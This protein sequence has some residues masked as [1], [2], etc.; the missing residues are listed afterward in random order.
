MAILKG[1]IRKLNGSAGDF[2]FKQ[3]NGQTVVSE[4][5]TTVKNARTASQ[6][7]HRTKWANMVQMYKGI[8]PLLLCGFENKAQSVSDYNMFMKVNI[9]VSPVYLSK[10]DVAGGACIA[11]PYQLTQGTLP[12]IVVTGSG[13]TRTTNISVGSLSI[14]ADTT[15]K[16]FSDAVVQNNADYDYGD[17][18]SFFL[19][20][21]KTNAVTGVPYCQFTA[22]AVN[23]DKE[24]TAKLQDTVL[25]AGFK[26]SGGVLA[27]DVTDYGDCVYAWVHSRKSSS[28]TCVSTQFL[29][30]NNSL[31]PAYTS[32]E[33]CDSASTSYGDSKDVFL[34]PDGTS[35][36]SGSATTDSSSGDSSSGSG[37]SSG[38]GSDSGSGSS[39]GGSS[40]GG[41]SS[42]DDGGVG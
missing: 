35:T 28:K 41:S 36:T 38:S 33:A 29:L 23:L 15:V 16:Q 1:L 20:V 11:A 34:S 22:S 17:Q 42:E 24:S 12:S 6:M 37:G 9:N 19:I 7:K 18:I 13:A 31:L 30:D 25:T 40:S 39:S 32:D 27:A 14:G 26:V 4:K 21:Q 10:Q 2:T 8:S 5:V 3:V